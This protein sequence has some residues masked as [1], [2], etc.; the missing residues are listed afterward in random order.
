MVAS[1]GWDGHEPNHFWELDRL[2]P[3]LGA[4][5][6][7]A[8]PRISGSDSSSCPAPSHEWGWG[9]ELLYPR[10]RLGKAPGVPS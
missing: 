5:T 10:V 8:G 4:Q 3:E 7:D 6:L 9:L 1:W 2:Q